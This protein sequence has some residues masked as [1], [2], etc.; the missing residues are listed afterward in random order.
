MWVA[1]DFN[2]LHFP[3]PAAQGEGWVWCDSA[4]CLHEV[5][6]G[7]TRGLPSPLLLPL[8]AQRKGE[9]PSPAP[10]QAAPFYGTGPHHSPSASIVLGA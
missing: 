2:D 8:Q 10:Q 4:H 5:L 6:P 3:F 7:E 9:A 1:N